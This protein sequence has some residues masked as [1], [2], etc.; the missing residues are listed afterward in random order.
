MA[1]AV[2]P[3]GYSAPP[4]LTEAQEMD[5][6][7]VELRLRRRAVL[8]PDVF[9]FGDGEDLLLP[10]GELM[11]YLDFP[12]ESDAATGRANGWFLRETQGFALNADAGEVE[13]AG[14]VFAFD[15]ERVRTD[16]EDLYV[17]LS[18]LSAWFGLNS[19]WDAQSQTVHLE[20]DYLLSAEERLRREGQRVSSGRRQSQLDLSEL[21]EIDA[22][23]AW[24]GWPHG[25]AD[26]SYNIAGP[27][28]DIQ[29][30][31]GSIA[32]TGDFLKMTGEFYGNADT[33]GSRTA[34]MVLGRTD[35]SGR[36]FSSVLGSY[37]ANRIQLGDIST[38]THP[39]L[40]GG[41]A[42][43]GVALS[44]SRLRQGGDFDTTR[45]EGEAFAGWQAEL[46]R[47]G[48]LLGFLTIPNSGRYIFDDIP[49]SFGVNR[50]RVELYG[51]LGERRTID[52]PVDVSNSFVRQGDVEYN[53]EFALLGQGVFT[54]ARR[55]A[56]LDFDGTI[57]D[58]DDVTDASGLSDSLNGYVGYGEIA[59][60]LTQALSA[61]A[62]LQVRGGET[63]ADRQT[64]FVSLAQRTG[65][66]V[67]NGDL[68]VDNRGENAAR[69]SYSTELRGVSLT[70]FL[71]NR[72]DYFGLE[73]DEDISSS[74]VRRA[75]V[76]LDGRFNPPG[77]SRQAGWSA[78]LARNERADGGADHTAQARLSGQIAGLSLS[79][80]VNW[81][82]G[83]S[84]ASGA[85]ETGTSTFSVSGTVNDFRLRGSLDADLV[86]D[87]EMSRAQIEVSRRYRDW[88]G[89]LRYV[90][91][92]S[93][94]GASYGFGLSRDF[95]GVRLGFDLRHDEDNSQTSA[96][97]TL[98]FDFD[99]HPGGTG[100]RFG[101]NARSDRGVANIRVYEDLDLDGV[102]SP[103]TDRV[104]EDAGVIV[105]P[106]GRLVTNDERVVIDDLST[107]QMIGVAVDRNQLN[108]P[109]LIPA[110]EG[111]RFTA[112]PSGA[113]N[114]NL[115]VVLSGEVELALVTETGEPIE[116][117]IAEMRSCP[118]GRIDEHL[119][120]RS[121]YDGYVFFQFVK[122]GCYD[123]NVPGYETQRLYVSSGDILRP[124]LVRN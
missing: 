32:L 113:V 19:E 34:R 72:S 102:Y 7:I 36:L 38:T 105:E 67:L 112:R 69:L 80:T 28:P 99:R 70:A 89:R 51:P 58:G 25:S 120:E 122:P 50:F 55:A 57:D 76:R 93:S 84:D 16:G 44:R 6:R 75:N 15:P 65:V 121:A 48:E 115:P 14:Q 3:N 61:T 110:S 114:I 78:S 103:E 21:E 106:R 49:L 60:G 111:A 71:E 8:A 94:D 35:A 86:P 47:D 64:G 63:Q 20:P 18:L 1:T 62:G 98:G 91:D 24:I 17:P 97:F 68:A 5:F 82:W 10:L 59:M 74:V 88:Y 2:S 26:L 79:E 73:Y 96:M 87:W 100:M 119:R 85:T 109:Y 23:Y 37:G 29:L 45:I 43:L 116:G 124:D 27:D 118:D 104:I 117:R 90:R 13:I 54:N 33:D 92:F 52:R 11:Y 53:L 4:Y 41:G 42:G 40:Q 95:D 22:P 83:D 56:E 39:L 101:R 81:R 9:A 66:H 108:D 46:Y 31:T 30:G 12:I 77:L 107:D 123:L